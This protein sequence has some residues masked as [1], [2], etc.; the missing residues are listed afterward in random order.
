MIV[1]QSHN[2]KEYQVKDDVLY[3]DN[4][5]YSGCLT[6]E[7]EETTSQLNYQN[8]KLHGIQKTYFKTGELKQASIFTRGLENGRRVEYYKC[9]SKKLNA[10]FCNGLQEGIA[11]EWEENGK[12]KSRKTYYKGKLIAVMANP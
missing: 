6:E 10:N 2:A 5:P 3:Y 11:E 9:G 12:I 4:C 7:L 1:A 8:G